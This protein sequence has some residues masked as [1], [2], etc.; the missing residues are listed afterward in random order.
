[1]RGTELIAAGAVA[2]V[3]EEACESG[4]LEDLRASRA[5]GANDAWLGALVLAGLAEH[6][7]ATGRTYAAPLVATA[8]ALLPQGLSRERD[9]V[10]AARALFGRVPA[11]AYALAIDT[12]LPGRLADAVAHPLAGLHFARAAARAK[13]GGQPASFGAGEVRAALL[14][15]GFAEVTITPLPAAPHLAVFRATVR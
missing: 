10:A 9:P 6:D 5:T 7:G 3:L 1:M 14:A 12:A 11:G 2:Q 13:S 4:L 15:A 8:A